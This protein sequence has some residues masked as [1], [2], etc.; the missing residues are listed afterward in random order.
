MVTTP[1]QQLGECAWKLE[2]LGE[3]LGDSVPLRKIAALRHRLVHQYEGINWD[4]AEGVLF[5]DVPKLAED[6]VPIL[7]QRG[8]QPEEFDLG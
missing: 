7:I 8:I 6:L 5:E 2:K 3:D 4:V 1:L